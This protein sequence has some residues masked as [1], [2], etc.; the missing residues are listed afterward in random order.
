MTE[1]LIYVQA[2]KY[3]NEETKINEL[4]HEEAE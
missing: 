4:R 3:L 2:K 1:L